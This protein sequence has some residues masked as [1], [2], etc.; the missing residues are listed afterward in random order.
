MTLN[1]PEPI[2]LTTSLEENKTILRGVIGKNSDIVFRDI[3]MS[4]NIRATV[5]YVDGMT[6][7][8]AISQYIIKPLLHHGE[9][10]KTLA[11]KALAE[12]VLYIPDIKAVQE[13]Q[14]FLQTIYSGDCGLL[15]DGYVEGIVTDIKGFS[16][17]G[18]SEPA[19]EMV[20]RGSREGFVENMKTNMSMIRR[21]IKTPNLAFEM[22][23][24]GTETETNVAIAYIRGLVPDRLIQE[25]KT[26]LNHIKI[27]SLLE[28]GYIEQ[29]TEDN[30]SSPFASIG[31]SE[32][33]D[34]VVAKMLEG[35]VAIIADG[36]PF[37]LTV[38]MLFM[39]NFQSAED[40]YS[41]P[42]L[43]S[44]IRCIRFLAFM[45][46]VFAPAVYVAIVIYHH[47]VIP[48]KLML[49]MWQ[50]EANTPFNSGLSILLITIL[51]EVVREAGVR[52]PRPVGAAISIVGGLVIGD[53]VVSAGLISAPVVIIVAFT[54]ISM[55]VVDAM[56]DA[57]TVLRIGFIFL[58]WFF[59]FFGLFIG[60]LMLLVHLVSMESFGVPYLAPFA[61]FMRH[62]M[63]D[64]FVRAPLWLLGRRPK[65][66]S[67]GTKWRQREAIPPDGQ[68][69]QPPL[70]RR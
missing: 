10:A 49:N 9:K 16:T 18:I 62:E 19:T 12:Q 66:L 60:G 26:R 29:L 21:R 4:G 47:E 14:G 58:A 31:N 40:Y 51:Y 38:P 36:T 42:Y 68:G 65:V 24:I 23:Q 2:K 33:P 69:E 63:R 27:D 13:A 15:V 46:G 25:V 41:R 32:K 61:P 8:D 17:R 67:A 30:P 6:D 11:P 55:F 70:E 3:E 59:G 44:F 20:V 34:K 1:K 5:V 22:M 28:S 48:Y 64:T 39:E 7:K 43:A 53:M 57:A 52:L 35:R 54:A 45:I 50:A 56:T 37:V